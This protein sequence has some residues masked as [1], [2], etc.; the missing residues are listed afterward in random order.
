M[1]I[2][3]TQLTTNF[4]TRLNNLT[5]TETSEEILSLTAALNNITSNRFMSVTSYSQ[6]PNLNTNS[7]PSGTLIFVEQLNVFLMS[8]G[9]QWRGVDGRTLSFTPTTMYSWGRNNTGQLGD[10]TIT[11][12]SSPGTI[13][14]SGINNWTKVSAGREYSLAITSNG[15]AYGWG[16]NG[17]GTLGNG[18]TVSTLNP[19]AVVGGIIN[20]SSISAGAYHSLG[21]T[22]A[23]VAYA[24][25]R[26][27][28][29]AL[30]D[31]TSVNKSSPVSV[32]GNLNWTQVSSGRL[33]S[34][35]VT[36]TGIAYGWGL[37]TSGKLGNGTTTNTSSPVSIIGVNNWSQVSAGYNHSIG[38]T[39]GGIAYGW[40]DNTN[41]R[42]GTNGISPSS[43]G[44]VIGGINNW[45]QVSAG[46]KHNLGITSTGRAYG[47]GANVDG[48]LGDGST[49]QRSS[50]VSVI[51]GFTNW[52]QVSAGSNIYVFGG[53]GAGASVGLTSAGRAYVWGSNIDGELGDGT[54]VSKS[55]PVEV[56][57][58]ITTWSQVSAGAT[59]ST[60]PQRGIHMLGLVT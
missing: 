40:G 19:V 24:W 45:S 25:G 46:A 60:N 15:I 38:V 49:V 6:L 39:S 16:Y 7:I 56:V 55:S 54:A 51:G 18:T 11:D 13:I 58:G 31:G 36:N 53:A 44:T 29:G 42:L 30:G 9:T 1:S 5:G 3:T 4:Q 35:G 32:I 28:E 59:F 37:N 22:S 10:G 52:S 27:G 21:V 12:R 48:Q 50:P 41:S 17:N 2:N 43:P 23:G 33:H 34:L 8:V 14:S 57:G 26:N 47:W 20:W